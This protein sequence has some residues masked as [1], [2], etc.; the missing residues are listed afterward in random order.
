[1]GDFY[2]L[3]FDDAVKAAAALDIQL[4]KRGHHNGDDIP[5]C[6]VPVH[7][8]EAYL[9]RLIKAGFRVA[10]CEQLEDPAEAKKRGPKVALKRDVVR[11][12]TP[13]TLTEDAL[14]DAR[15]NNYLAAL[16]EARGE[17]ALA[18]L[19][20]STGAFRLQSVP[21]AGLAAALARL[22]PGE[23][24]V[25]E[26]LVERPDLYELWNDWKAALTPLPSPRFDSENGRKRLEEFYGV[27]ALDGFGDF[28]RAELAAG[29]ALLDYVRLT[30]IGRLPLLQVPRRLAVD[31]VMEIDPATRRNLELTEMLVRRAPGQPACHDRPNRDRRR[32]AALGGAA[33]DAADRSRRD[34]RAARRGRLSARRHAARATKSA[35]GCA[36]PAISNA[37]WRGCRSGAA[38]RAISPAC[39]TR[40]TRQ[41]RSG[42]FFPMARRPRSSRHRA[43]S[44]NI[45]SSPTG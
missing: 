9:A 34:R 2:E 15:R 14:L 10:V 22:A 24:L 12:V 35:T 20:L 30:Q 32:R 3:F 40:S 17:M 45:M 29:G 42:R 11:I 5:M 41:P 26:R 19:D 37:R 7:T 33:C 23:L 21:A 38:G 16:A 4:T 43:T 13:G 8:A 18:W 36:R 31:A 6:G 28:A 44:A 27:R 25:P 1:M 39:A